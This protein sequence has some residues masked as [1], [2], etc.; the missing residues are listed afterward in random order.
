MQRT[1]HLERANLA[2]LP[3][4]QRL[5]E[6]PRI[7]QPEQIPLGARFGLEVPEHPAP[8]VLLV[9]LELGLDVAADVV[10]I[11][12]GP[13]G[14][15]VDGG[16]G[17]DEGGARIG[18]VVAGADEVAVKG[19]GAVGHGGGP[20]TDDGPVRL[21]GGVGHGVVADELAMLL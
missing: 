5:R 3:R 7:Q 21:V 12:L 1:T 11:G 4:R 18:A 15:V 13:G 9:D 2:K 6:D 19:R 17:A 14:E 10:A 20:F 16:A 8:R